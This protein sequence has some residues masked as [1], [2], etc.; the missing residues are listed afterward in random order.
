M[1]RWRIIDTDI[2]K[3]EFTAAADDAI[4]RSVASD[5]S[6]P[7]LHFYRRRPPAVT[8]GRFLNAHENV[9]INKCKEDG[10]KIIRRLSG[11]GAIYTSEGQLIY[12]FS[13]KNVMTEDVSTSIKIICRII[14]KSL[15]KM[16]INAVFH[17]KNDILLNGRKISGS[18]QFRLRKYNTTLQHGTIIVHEDVRKMFS[19]LKVSD[20]RLRK[21]KIKIAEDRVTS[22]EKEF[23]NIRM[24]DLKSRIIESFSEY[25]NVTF[26]HG[27]MTEDERKMALE[28]IE[29][30]YDNE[31]WNIEGRICV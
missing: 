1:S 12:S 27:N 19:Y 3:P 5:I 20:A 9:N 24:E 16:G 11:G 30:K 28:L 10:V 2:A 4:L 22:I 18:A 6:P 23:G 7:T 25:F 17:G 26:Y 8:I 14:E 31:G 15:K 21:H 29:K 13:S